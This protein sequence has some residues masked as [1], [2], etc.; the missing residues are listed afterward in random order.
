M[1]ISEQYREL[2]AKLHEV[3]PDY[4]AGGRKWA[5]FTMDICQSLRTREVLDYGCGKAT[6]RA[7][8]PML[9][10]VNYDP[11]IEEFAAKPEPRDVVVCTDVLEHI[12]PN[13]LPAVLEDLQ[14]VTQRALLTVIATRPAVKFL[15]D[16][17]NAHLIVNAYDWWLKQFW[18]HTNL[19]LTSFNLLNP[20]EF[21]AVWEDPE[22][23][24]ANQEG[25]RSQ[26]A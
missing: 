21:M 17:R 6:L 18:E 3:R 19:R 26:A 5:N 2:N 13:F 23:Y 22:A 4:G 10:V 20:G 14:R 8:C 11:A 16:G 24:A 1:T 25:N 15:E 9:D 12:E 7:T